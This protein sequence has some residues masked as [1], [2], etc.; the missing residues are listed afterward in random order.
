MDVGVVWKD[1]RGGI[2]YG[3]G[4]QVLLRGSILH[5]DICATLNRSGRL[6]DMWHWELAG[7]FVDFDGAVDDPSSHVLGSE[8]LVELGHG[9]I[10]RRDDLLNGFRDGHAALEELERVNLSTERIDL[11][12]GEYN[13]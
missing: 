10:W 13:R 12:R 5:L 1:A 2:V 4:S 11:A 8:D 9:L 6:W 7:A 3:V